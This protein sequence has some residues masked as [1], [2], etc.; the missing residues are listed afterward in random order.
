[1]FRS[2]LQLGPTPLGAALLVLERRQ[3]A[4]VYRDELL[5]QAASYLVLHNQPCE[6]DP[7]V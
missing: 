1:M 4:L 5:V 6:A 7:V 3:Q 2:L